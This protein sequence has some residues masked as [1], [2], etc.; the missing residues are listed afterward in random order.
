MEQAPEGTPLTDLPLEMAMQERLE[1]VLRLRRL[2]VLL[3]V[4]PVAAAAS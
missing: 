2:G 3:L 1:R 4:T